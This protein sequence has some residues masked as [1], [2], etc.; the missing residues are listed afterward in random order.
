[1][2]WLWPWLLRVM[3][4]WIS[5]NYPVTATAN[6]TAGVWYISWF[7]FDHLGLLVSK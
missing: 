5:C 3:H 6:F 1:M 7:Y 2:Q 4:R